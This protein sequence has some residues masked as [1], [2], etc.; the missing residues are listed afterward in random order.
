MVVHACPVGA[1]GPRGFSHRPA[2]NSH[3]DDLSFDLSR[4]YRS[5]AARGV[6]NDSSAVRPETLLVLTE[7]EIT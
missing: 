5:G 1:P 6:R 3:D 2:N 4:P 7:G